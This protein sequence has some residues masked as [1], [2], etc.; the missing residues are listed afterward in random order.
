MEMIKDKNGRDLMEA[1]D[2]K[3]MWQEYTEK[4][5]QKCLDISDNPESVVAYLEPDILESEIKWALESLAK[6][7]PVE[8]MAFHFNYLKSLKMMLLRCYTQ[9]ASKFGKLSSGRGLKKISLHPKPKEWQCQG[10][11]QLPYNCTHFTC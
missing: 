3:K 11:L 4:L 5:Y 10:M 2:M 9:Y 1:Q 6:T 7:R 8:V